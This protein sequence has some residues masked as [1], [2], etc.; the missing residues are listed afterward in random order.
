MWG[1]GYDGLDLTELKPDV[2]LVLQTE[3]LASYDST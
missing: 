3:Q 1:D 2:A